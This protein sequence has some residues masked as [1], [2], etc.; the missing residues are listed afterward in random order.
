MSLP[1]YPNANPLRQAL[2]LHSPACAEIGALRAEQRKIDTISCADVN[3]RN[4]TNIMETK[5]TLRPRRVPTTDDC[6]KSK[7]WKTIRPVCVLEQKKLFAYIQCCCLTGKHGNFFL[8]F[9][10][11]LSLF[12][13]RVFG[14]VIDRSE[15][16][17]LNV[18]HGGRRLSRG[19]SFGYQICIKMPEQFKPAGE[20]PSIWIFIG[21]A[22][23]VMS[24]KDFPC[25]LSI[26]TSRIWS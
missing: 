2:T 11:F 19:I 25:L 18:W 4:V 22:W 24:L 9:F 20:N 1:L 12:T 5:D 13:V 21:V 14:S 8:S 10:F 7:R 26:K 16:F 6:D 23:S 3:K 15:Y 17:S